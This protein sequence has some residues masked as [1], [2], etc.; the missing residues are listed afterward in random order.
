MPISNGRTELDIPTVFT[1]LKFSIQTECF[2]DRLAE[3]IYKYKQLYLLGYTLKQ[4]DFIRSLLF[5]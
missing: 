3:K 5:I 4:L 2:G 1:L